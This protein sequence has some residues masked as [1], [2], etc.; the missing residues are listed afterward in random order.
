MI[1]ILNLSQQESI[2]I[3]ESFEKIKNI[4]FVA[5]SVLYYTQRNI[6]NST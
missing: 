1:D 6:T 3:N 4:E 2:L 5:D